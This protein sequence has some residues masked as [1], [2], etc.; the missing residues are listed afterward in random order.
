VRSNKWSAVKLL[1]LTTLFSAALFLNVQQCLAS[2][3][4]YSPLLQFVTDR[5]EEGVLHAFNGFRNTPDKSS[6][7]YCLAYLK[8]HPELIKKIQSDLGGGEVNWSLDD[9]KERLLFAPERRR[10]FGELFQSYCMDVVRY[11]L[12]K[13]GLPNPYERVE[14]LTGDMPSMPNGQISAFIV[15]GLVKESVASYTFTN[16]GDKFVNIK[17]NDR[18]SL[19]EIGSYSSEINV[20]AD[21]ALHFVMNKYTVW[22]DCASNPYTVLMVPAEETLH[23]LLRKYTNEAIK[24]QVMHEAAGGSPDIRK[25]AE[26]WLA[27]EEAVVGGLVHSLL[28]P[29]LERHVGSLSSSYV[30][31]DLDSKLQFH[32]Y[33]YLRRGISLVENRGYRE[34]LRMYM[35]NPAK[36]RDLLE[37]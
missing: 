32:K 11:V 26:G 18:T 36:V 4:D 17:L 16:K 24:E 19:G 23:I 7:K 9:I 2:V 20:G 14:M 15:H 8:D 6:H 33:R 10:D 29:F 25:T 30:R 37:G 1:G 31:Q 34:V 13:T 22:Q 35:A 28:P 3:R 21:G 12:E 5:N 27:V